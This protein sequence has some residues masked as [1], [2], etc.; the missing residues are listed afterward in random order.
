MIKNFAVVS[1]DTKMVINTILIDESNTDF[2][3]LYESENNCSCIEFDTENEDDTKVAR[4][5]KIYLDSKF[6][7]GNQAIDLGLLTEDDCMRL[8]L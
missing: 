5:G 3:N 1:N 8:G 7:N 2:I 6:I 4:I